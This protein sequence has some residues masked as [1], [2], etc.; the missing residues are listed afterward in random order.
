MVAAMSASAATDFSVMSYNEIASAFSITVASA[1]T[2]T[3]RRRWEKRLGNDGCVRVHVPLDYLQES[4]QVSPHVSGP[5]SPHGSVTDGAQPAAGTVEAIAAL[6]RHVAR[7]EADMSAL[8]S[9]LM[10]ARSEAEE[11]KAKVHEE[12]V[13]SAAL[14]ATL[15]VLAE[16]RDRWHAVATTPRKSW[17]PWRRAG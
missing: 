15:S 13:V 1:K 16:E 2:L 11:A 10:S 7:L 14:K 9:A 8:S 12:A 6:E 17:L 5:D 4:R 3:R